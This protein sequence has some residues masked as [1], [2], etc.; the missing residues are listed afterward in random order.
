MPLDKYPCHGW[1]DKVRAIYYKYKYI[2]IYYKYKYIYIYTIYIYIYICIIYIYI[3]IYLLGIE[4][5]RNPFDHP[6]DHFILSHCNN[7]GRIV[8]GC[9]TIS[10]QKKVE[11]CV[12]NAS[13]R[14]FTSH[15]HVY[16]F[17]HIFWGRTTVR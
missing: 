14:P 8:M 2:Y 5:G 12:Q 16:I 9:T 11:P 17:F 10:S 1:L 7:I 4:L 15:F 13:S 6:F 3:Y